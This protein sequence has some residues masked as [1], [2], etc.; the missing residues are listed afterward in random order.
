MDPL[1]GLGYR[2]SDEVAEFA[3]LKQLQ[4][5]R[6]SLLLPGYPK[7]SMYPIIRYPLRRGIGFRGLE[8]RVLGFRVLGFRGPCTQNLGT[9]VLGNSIYSIGFG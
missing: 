2:G 3:I 8:F 5:G 1:R 9:W 6:C 7:G 4:D